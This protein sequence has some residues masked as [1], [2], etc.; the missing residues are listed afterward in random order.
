MHRNAALRIWKQL[1]VASAY[2]SI[3]VQI[4]IEI[5]PMEEGL[6]AQPPRFPIWAFWELC[7]K[8]GYIIHIL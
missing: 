4:Y 1:D 2:V 7:I 6:D 8:F 5:S 3:D